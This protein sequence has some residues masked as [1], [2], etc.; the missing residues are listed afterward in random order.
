MINGWW[1]KELNYKNINNW[2]TCEVVTTTRDIKGNPE[3]AI[4]AADCDGLPD[5]VCESKRDYFLFEKKLISNI[6]DIYSLTESKLSRLDRMGEKSA[7]NI[8]EA[9]NKSKKTSLNRFINGLGINHIGQNAA[10]ILSHNF[11][12][13]LNLLMNSGITCSWPISFP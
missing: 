12:N 10:K 8:I 5:W 13:D 6:S 9:I 4:T 7:T 3:G 11:N 1:V 2:P